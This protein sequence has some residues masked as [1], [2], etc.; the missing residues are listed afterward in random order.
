MSRILD[1]I[2]KSWR[3]AG[4]DVVLIVGSI[5][6]AF[7]LEAWWDGYGERRVESQQL[8]TLRAEFVATR[9]QLESFGSML[10]A[11]D[12]ATTSLLSVMGPEALPAKPDSVISL[13]SRS[14]IVGVFTPQQW[15]LESMLAGGNESVAGSDS[16][17]MALA[18]WP[19]VV[20]VLVLDSQHLERNRDVDLQSALVRAGV[21][22]FAFFIRFP[23]PEMPESA[24]AIDYDRLLRDLEV[25]AALSYRALRIQGLVSRSLPEALATL[26]SIV[27]RLDSELAG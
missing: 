20:E 16:L 15:A 5:L 11:A 6:V 18:R 14:F 9:S 22:G 7:S 13:L 17:S 1:K 26:D 3:D 27:G 19:G 10:Q 25:Y 12:E 24:F 8:A 23:G 4:R 21:P 2:G